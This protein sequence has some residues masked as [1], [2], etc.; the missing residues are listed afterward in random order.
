MTEPAELLGEYGIRLPNYR[1]GTQKIAC[2][3]AASC[4]RRNVNDPC[5]SVKIDGDGAT[6]KCHHCDWS[7][8]EK[9][10]HKRAPDPKPS[11]VER[12]KLSPL[13]DK[14]RQWLN[15]RGIGD[16]TLATVGVSSSRWW[17]ASKQGEADCIA[18]PY[19]APGGKLINAKF[20]T[21]DK[22]FAQVK[23]AGKV[24]FGIDRLDPSTG[25]AVICEGEIDA[26]SLMEA[27]V[28]NALS[29][30]DGAP[31]KLR[32]DWSAE[33]VAFSYLASCKD[34]LGKLRRIVLATDA[35]VPGENLREELARRLGR[36]RCYLVTWPEG[37]KDAND[38]LRA[39]GAE[40]LRNLIDVAAPYPVK[41]VYEANQ[42]LSDV[43]SL[44]RDGRARGMSTGWA[45]VDEFY[46]VRPGE[47]TIVTGCPNMGKSEWVDA[48]C[49]NLAS[50]HGWKFGVCS[51]ENPPGEHL[52]KLAE[53]RAKMP[54]WDGPTP[55]MSEEKL[56]ESVAW[57]N[58]HFA[59]I[60]ADDEA[61]TFDW[62]L[63]AAKGAALRLG[64]SGLVIDPYNELEHKRPSNQTETEYV[65]EIL[66]K[67]KRFCQN[68]GVHAWFIAHPAKMLRDAKGNIPVP[69]LYDIS[70]SA[71]FVNKADNGIVVHRDPMS[72]PPQTDIHVR[73]VR[74]K[75]VGQVGQATLLYDKPTGIYSDLPRSADGGRYSAWDGRPFAGSAA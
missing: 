1:H 52:A 39:H 47:L 20:R 65:S 4:G 5:L 35:D 28:E 41:S 30:P 19:R 48:L 63:E 34:D 61:P 6:W 25:E 60:R 11:G 57:I 44:Y 3:R 69:T 15:G 32:E 68:H 73:K 14:A 45:G 53:K 64:I 49:V 70:G 33:D 24:L 21:G 12:V 31:S 9:G 40:Y 13:T 55:R 72:E 46:T 71:N 26:L 74:F 58:R 54:F 7:G 22:H 37:C 2:P 23:G 16:S 42:F 59:F 66:G 67:L 38:T 27:G 8:P 75:S 29:V 18:F 51:F 43:L 50:L 10:A 56:R 62:L 36:D 17:F